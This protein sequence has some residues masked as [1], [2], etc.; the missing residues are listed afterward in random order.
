MGT[1]TKQPEGEPPRRI[2]RAVIISP[3]TPSFEVKITATTDGDMELDVVEGVAEVTGD[4]L[5]IS[6]KP[7]TGT[8]GEQR[9]KN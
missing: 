9:F 8:P 5:R 7:E 1:K 2:S 4:R 6:S 3:S